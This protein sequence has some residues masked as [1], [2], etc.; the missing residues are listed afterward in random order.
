MLAPS[1][2]DSVECVLRSTHAIHLPASRTFQ[3]LPFLGCY[4]HTLLTM[5]VHTRTSVS[6]TERTPRS[7]I[8]G[9]VAMHTL[10]PADNDIVTRT[11]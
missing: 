4:E 3:G 9:V 1:E 5:L 2:N 6:G 11:C 7:G 10:D 8:A